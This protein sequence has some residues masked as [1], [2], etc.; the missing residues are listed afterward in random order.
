MKQPKRCNC[1]DISENSY[2]KIAAIIVKEGKTLVVKK[3]GL[4]EFIS[5]GGKHE[6]DE[7]DEECLV[8]ESLEELNTKVFNPI[9]L[10]RFQDRAISDNN[11]VILD[12]YLV[13]TDDIPT[14]SNEIEDF[15]WVGKTYDIKIA[16]IIKRFVIPELNKKGLLQ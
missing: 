4:D 6:G 9:F 15:A 16:S 13:Q 14:P 10:G 2:H 12:A 1:D 11:L 5:L 3:K 7:S 8:R